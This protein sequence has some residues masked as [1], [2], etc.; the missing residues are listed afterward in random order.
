MATTLPLDT[1]GSV[2]L[3]GAGNGTVT[4]AP[5]YG[6]RWDIVSTTVSTVSQASPLPQCTLSSAGGVLDAT[7]T[8]NGDATDVPATLYGGQALQAAWTGGNP[9]DRATVRVQGTVTTGYRGGT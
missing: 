4:L 3:N 1:S 8:G 7:F 9:G 5:R 2:V 6:Q